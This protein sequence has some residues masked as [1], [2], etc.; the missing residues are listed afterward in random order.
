MME[1]GLPVVVVQP[2]G[3]FGPG[4]KEYGSVRSPFVDWFEGDLPMLPSQ[5]TLPYDYARVS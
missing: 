3:V 1:D 4:D 2:G 5:L